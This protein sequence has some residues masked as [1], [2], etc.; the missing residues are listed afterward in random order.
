M[1]FILRFLNKRTFLAAAGLLAVALAAYYS[2]DAALARYLRWRYPDQAAA[3]AHK[4]EDIRADLDRQESLRLRG[5]YRQVSAEIAAA[6]AKGFDVTA[7]QA[8]A[9][10][11][12]TLDTPAY[13]AAAVERLNKLRLAIPQKPEVVRP[14]DDQDDADADRIPTPPAHAVGRPRRRR[15]R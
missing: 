8:V 11:A 7:L 2:R 12:L 4:A 10:Q 3:A 5:L 1:E 9:D 14:A 15:P 13:R 6:G